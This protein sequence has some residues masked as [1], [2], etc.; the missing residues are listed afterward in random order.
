M[1]CYDYEFCSGKHVCPICNKNKNCD[2]GAFGHSATKGQGICH[3]KNE[4]VF[5]QNCQKNRWDE[6]LKF[7]KKEGVKI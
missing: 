5:C 3:A 4:K 1:N 2:G 7:H 6:I